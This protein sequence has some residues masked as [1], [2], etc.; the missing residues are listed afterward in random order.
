MR[1]RLVLAIPLLAAL[2]LA[3]SS[4]AGAEEWRKGGVLNVAIIGEPPTLDP[5][6][7]TADV[8]AVI[9]HHFFETLFA[10][11]EGFSVKPL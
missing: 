9:S 7:T 1:I 5:T 3:P 2:F 8:V 6:V 4:G 11:G 10:F